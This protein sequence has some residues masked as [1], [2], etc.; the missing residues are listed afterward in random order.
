MNRQCTSG[1][2]IVVLF[3]ILVF[4]AGCGGG[5]STKQ[6]N[7]STAFDTIKVPV[8]SGNTAVAVTHEVK[9]FD[10]WYRVYTDE[11]DPQS[12]LSI[13]A[14]P[15]DPNLITVFELT[16][17]HADAKNAFASDRLR[18]AMQEAGVTS[19]PVFHYY[20]VKFRVSGATEKIYRLGVS[21]E[22]ENY[23]RW[24]KVFDEDEP[25]RAKANLELRAISLDAD[26]PNMVNI[27]FATDNIEKAKEVIN[28]DELRKR[29]QDAGVR[30]E[31]VF[32]VLTLPKK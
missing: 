8:Y 18:K 20:D 6:E 31:P 4:N 25:I 10:A 3:V 11:S 15:D 5:N 24:K 27:M 23:E 32:T 13:F 29:M 14:S 26:N 12:R 16:K 19:D 2:S 22:V 28:S 17:S 21:H 9:S 7:N 30:S 1:L